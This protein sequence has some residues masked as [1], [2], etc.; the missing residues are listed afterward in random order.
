VPQL[1]HLYILGIVVT[2][3]WQLYKKTMIFA[4]KFKR[5]YNYLLEKE[6]EI[7]PLFLFRRKEKLCR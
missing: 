4:I 5:G 6:W 2:L 7:P 3:Q 1:G